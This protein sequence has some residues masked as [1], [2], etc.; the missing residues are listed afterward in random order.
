[1]NL[2]YKT[3]MD[4]DVQ[5]DGL[6][7][8]SLRKDAEIQKSLRC[9]AALWWFTPMVFLVVVVSISGFLWPDTFLHFYW[10]YMILIMGFLF[11]IIRTALRS[12]SDKTRA[13]KII[14]IWEWGQFIRDYKRLEWIQALETKNLRKTDDIILIEELVRDRANL[15]KRQNSETRGV[16]GAVAAIFLLLLGVVLTSMFSFMKTAEETSL[17]ARESFLLLLH[18]CVILYFL[19]MVMSDVLF[20]RERKLFEL[21]ATLKDIAYT[22]EMQTGTL[23][24]QTPRSP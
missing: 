12:L 13:Q 21:A 8:W 10:S 6:L 16:P 18:I 3:S 23:F 11:A 5:K 20:G 2:I 14:R 4:V 19:R 9:N 15:I 17:M 24:L 1:M 7:Q 22:T